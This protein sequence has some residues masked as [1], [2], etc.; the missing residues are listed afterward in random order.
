MDFSI[1]DSP[2]RPFDLDA[3][4]DAAK[5]DEL[6]DQMA[7]IHSLHKARLE[8]SN[9]SAEYIHRIRNPIQETL[10]IPEDERFS[11]ELY[12]ALDRASQET[13]S[14]VCAAVR[15]RHPGTS[16]LTFEQVH[17][18]VAELSGI[19][20]ITHDMCIN[21]CLAYTGKFEHDTECSLCGEP[22]YD[23]K[24]L[25]KS[26]GKSRIPQRQFHTMPIGPQIQACFRHPESA[27]KMRYRSTQTAEV[28]RRRKIDVYEDFIHGKDYLE[29]VMAGRIGDD[30]VCLMFSI[31]G[32]Q[33]YQNKASDCWIYIWVIL[34]YSP[35]LRYKK[36]YIMPGA[37]IPGPKKP[38]HLESFLLP[39]LAHLSALQQEGLPIWDAS[40]NR[41]FRSNPFLL[42]AT[43][44]APG[45]ALLNRLVGHHG[46]A[47]C[48][49]YCGTPGRH[50]AG[51]SHYYPALRKP[52]DYTISGSDHPDIN[53]H[54]VNTT[55]SCKNY[56]SNL[57]RLIKA[58]NERQFKKLRLD[59]GIAK[60]SLFIGLQS[61]RIL[62]IPNIFTL[63]IMHLASLN[64]SDLLLQL[65]RAG[66]DIR[67]TG[68]SGDNIDAWEWAV[69]RD[70]RVW[71]KHGQTVAD[72]RPFFPGSFDRYL[73]NPAEKI[74]SGYKA[75]EY[76]NYI[77][78]LGPGLFLN[79]LPEPFYSHFCKLVQGMRIM[80]QHRIPVDRLQEAH[81]LLLEFVDGFETFYYERMPQRLQFV[82]QS[83]HVLLHVGTETCRIGPLPICSQWPMERTIGNLGEEIKQHSNPFSNLSERGVRRC[84]VNALKAMIPELDLK[85]DKLPQGAEDLGDEYCL[86]RARD[87]SR[88]HPSPHELTAIRYY[89]R[90]A[91][92][93]T[94]QWLGL[95]PTSSN[96]LSY[97]RWA[98]LAIPTGQIARSVFKECRMQTVRMSRM[99]KVCAYCHQYG[100]SF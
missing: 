89:F 17:R 33:L 29:A 55:R 31:D 7:F 4:S 1:E 60:P 77:Y 67:D 27:K 45:M 74:N 25:H 97:Y 41:V 5:T 18:R 43:A 15:R 36:K 91:S 93:A 85:Q 53:I 86:L 94:L 26:G 62:G 40:Q 65:W 75:Y 13:Y 51:G 6:K 90:S 14:A 24:V 61:D 76:L 70:D 8:D 39:G 9:L 57:D 23:Q 83:I 19:T 84:R 81:R 16:I 32:A 52:H 2:H 69:L 11:I 73:R 71:K 34:D 54:E 72:A 44:D 80:Q 21:T 30:D 87:R 78:G 98:R 58:P 79:L 88:Y 68:H 42:M 63:D 28:I 46:K 3:L 96:T 92:E 22:R 47:G 66:K 20:Q 99:V 64:L 10:E 59:T 49:L 100:G 37:F 38:K 50:K 48:R 35:D 56:R 12:L 95:F 82:R